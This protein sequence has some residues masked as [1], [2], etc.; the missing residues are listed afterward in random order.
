MNFIIA[1]IGNASLLKNSK[2][3]DLAFHLGKKLI[4]NNYIL[5]TGGMGGVM[6]FASKGARSSEN[7]S[8]GKIIGILPQ[9]HKKMANK[10]IDIPIATGL[11]LMRNNILISTADAVISIGGGSG[12]LN[13]LSIAWQM[14]KLIISLES[15]GWSNELANRQLDNRRND[16]IF[17]AKNINEA[18]QILNKNILEYSKK[19]FDG[20]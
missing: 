1:V 6:E 4:D 16:Q 14:N 18:I 20:V 5:A 12:T 13:E 15:D 11:E 10:Y 17:Q 2:K 8:F 9:N 7:Y 19:G 3:S